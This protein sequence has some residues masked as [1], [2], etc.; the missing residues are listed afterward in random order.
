MIF[1]LAT[2]EMT[3]FVFD[4]EADAL[5]YCEG[6]DVED[7]GWR[8]WDS[9]GKALRPEFTTPNKHAWF[10]SCNG[11]YRLVP[12]S[13]QPSLVDAISTIHGINR[14]KFFTSISAVKDYIYNSSQ[15]SQHGA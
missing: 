6:I 4:T 15:A 5:G 10:G 9:A 12:S 13:D 8:F 2:D 3:L 11:I 14:N 1:A 7:D